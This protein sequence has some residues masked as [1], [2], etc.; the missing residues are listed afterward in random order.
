MTRQSTICMTYQELFIGW[1]TR[2][3]TRCPRA[4]RG[5]CDLAHAQLHGCC[6]ATTASQ[7][8][9]SPA[10]ATNAKHLIP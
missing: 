8:A 5:H 6:S 4:P 3:C 2:R 1:L 10:Q 9:L 7:L